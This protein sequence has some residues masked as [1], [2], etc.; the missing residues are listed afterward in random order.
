MGRFFTCINIVNIELNEGNMIWTEWDKLTEIIVGSTYD[1]NSF[2]DNEDSEFVD[3]LSKIL[4]ETEEDFQ[5]L[6]N[7]FT[8]A[9]VKVHRPKKMKLSDEKT[10]HWEAKFPYPAICPRDHHIVYGDRILK[11]FGGDCNRYT[12]G[13]Y[14]VDIMLDKFQEGRNFVSMPS[15][16]LQSQYQ[17]YETMEPQIMYHAANIIKCGDAVLHTKPYEDINDRSFDARGT[18]AGLEWVKRNMPEDTRF[19]EVPETGHVDGTIALIKPGLLMT[20][21]KKNIPEELKDWDYIILEPWDLPEWFNEMRQ[22]HFYKEKVT[23]WLGHWIGHVD[24]TVFDLNVVSIDE[25]TLITNGYNKRIADKLKEH[26]VE[27]IPFDFRHKYFWDSGLHCVTL[28]LSREGSREKY[29]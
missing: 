28:D 8:S 12:E 27:M 2:D 29:V 14:F 7:V 26:G 6:S 23:D 16:I 18:Y 3:N 9:G 15:P 25:N 20:W 4:E 22:H 24:E 5:K 11:T 10:R 1:I 19:I 13:D 21:H 17:H